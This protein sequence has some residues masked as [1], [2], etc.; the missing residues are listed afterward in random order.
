MKHVVET[1]KILII[2]SIFQNVP[3]SFQTFS[4]MHACKIYTPLVVTS[5]LLLNCWVWIKKGKRSHC[6]N[7]YVRKYGTL[8]HLIFLLVWYSYFI[9]WLMST[10]ASC[11][12][13]TWY[14]KLLSQENNTLPARLSVP[15]FVFQHKYIYIQEYIT[16]Y[17]V[18]TIYAVSCAT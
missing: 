13:S 8:T 7:I 14:I 11:S 9:I 3:I 4:K 6:P 18:L 16:H 12:T 15:Y 10:R 2:R 5:L 17:I 1:L